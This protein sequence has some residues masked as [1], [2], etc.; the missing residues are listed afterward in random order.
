MRMLILILYIL[1]SLLF[2]GRLDF[3]EELRQSYSDCYIS[4]CSESDRITEFS[5]NKDICLTSAQSSSLF[6]N[7]NSNNVS[8]RTTSS[9]RQSNH[10]QMH[11]SFLSG[12]KFINIISTYPFLNNMSFMLS[13]T[14]TTGSFLFVICR[15]R[16]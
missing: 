3:A 11:T 7:S 15:L 5:I 13:G 1:L 10:R 9:G 14:R 12:S 8:V 16:L 2:G 4:E 6:G